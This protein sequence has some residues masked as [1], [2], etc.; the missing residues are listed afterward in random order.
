M[1]ENEY[2]YWKDFPQTV[3]ENK[4]KLLEILKADLDSWNSV[5]KKYQELNAEYENVNAIIK[6]NQFKVFGEGAKLHKENKAKARSI[7][8]ELDNIESEY[9]KRMSTHEIIERKIAL[10]ESL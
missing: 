9:K 1:C 6:Q 2:N 8:A 3:I 4:D 7:K 5:N 10:L